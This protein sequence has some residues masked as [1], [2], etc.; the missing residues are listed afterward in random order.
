MRSTVPRS[1]GIAVFAT[2][3]ACATVCFVVL[4]LVALFAKSGMTDSLALLE[5]PQIAPP[6]YGG[7]F[8]DPVFGT[9]VQRVTEPE[10][11][12]AAGVRCTGSACRHR[13]SSTQAW[14][15]DQSLLVI[16]KGCNDMCFLDG[17]TYRP[18]FVRKVRRDH[19]CKWHPLE[20]DVMICVRGDGVDIWR[21]A[22]NSWTQVFDRGRYRRLEFGPYKG[23]P[24][25]DG[26]RIALRALDADGRPVA[27]AL[28]VSPVVKHAD[29]ALTALDGVN[30]HVAISASGR[31]V[32]IAQTSGDGRETAYVFTIDGRMVQHW[33]EHHRPG[34]GDMTRDRDGGDIY[35]GISKSTPDEFQVIKRRLD[36]GRVTV[37]TASGEASHVSTRN[38][39]LPGWAFVS[40]QGS[41]EHTRDMRYAAPFYSEIVAVRIDSSDHRRLVHAR[42]AEHDYLSEI[43]A[44]PSPDGSRVIFASNWGQAGAPVSSF[45]ADVGAVLNGTGRATCEADA[46]DTRVRKAGP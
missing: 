31:Y 27:F 39:R 34:H 7:R 14:N 8:S 43:H 17:R 4:L 36:D 37:L 28:D 44:S 2:S 30:R 20:S 33:R 23:N 10:R 11:E 32:Y 46:C 18:L 13:Y 3:L 26:N 21:P 22:A 1:P 19:D 15:A 45:V 42:A 29:I 35:V 9:P 38:T 41:Y 16:D 24:S 6:D 40:F 5:T 12:L 25:D